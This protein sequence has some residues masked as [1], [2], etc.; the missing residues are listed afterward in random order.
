MKRWKPDATTILLLIVLG[1][2]VSGW[3]TIR[4][5]EAGITR[6]IDHY[7]APMQ[8]AVSTVQNTSGVEITVKTVRLDGEAVDAWMTRHTDA[9]NAAKAS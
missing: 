3:W 2:M 5:L 6:V 9:V 7:E 1:F 4:S 8:T